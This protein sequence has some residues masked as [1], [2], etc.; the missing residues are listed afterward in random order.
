VCHSETFKNYGMAL[1]SSSGRNR[2]KGPGIYDEPGVAHMGGR[3]PFRL[4]DICRQIV[5]GD[6]V[7]TESDLYEHWLVSNRKP[8]ALVDLVCGPD[9]KICRKKKQRT[10]Q[11]KDD[12]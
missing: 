3:T 11:K 1:D 10:K 6:D 12:L 8:A 4:A 7:L 5:S 9:K 2:L